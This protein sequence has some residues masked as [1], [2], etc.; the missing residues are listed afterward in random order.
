M[1]TRKEAGGV[2]GRGPSGGKRGPFP[3]S[4]AQEKCVCVY[5]CVYV[6]GDSGLS[7]FGLPDPLWCLRTSSLTPGWQSC[8]F[9]HAAPS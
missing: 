8:W 2:G 3:F 4:G 6:V 9:F 7:S 1:E 5:V